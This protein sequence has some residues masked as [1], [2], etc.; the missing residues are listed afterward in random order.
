MG[1]AIGRHLFP[2]PFQ[3]NR[4]RKIDMSRYPYEGNVF[5]MNEHMD[6]I[7]SEIVLLVTYNL[8]KYMKR[9]E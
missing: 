8:S 4:T 2:G 5:V 3:L 1:N 7:L 6:D 9:F